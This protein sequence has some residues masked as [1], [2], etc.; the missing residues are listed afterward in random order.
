MP[1]K[2]SSAFSATRLAADTFLVKETDDIYSENPHIYV[3]LVPL[4]NTILL[5]DTGCGGKSNEDVEITSLRE[6]L[7]TYEVEVNDGKALNSGGFM[8]YV[9]VTTHCHYDHILAIEQFQGSLILASSHSPSFLSKANIAEHSLCNSLGIKTPSYDPTLVP[10]NFSIHSPDHDKTLLDVQI[11][12]TPGHTPDEIA[13]YDTTNNLLYVGDTLYED[14]PII[15]PKEGSIVVWLASMDFLI[16]FVQSIPNGQVLLNA[17][18]C[19]VN[20]PAL[21]MLQSAKGFIVDVVEGKE[22]VVKRTMKRGEGT[23]E[24]RQMGGR[25]S[26][27]CPEKLVLD[28]RKSL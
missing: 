5:I 28:A 26:L 11:L 22:K 18:H 20:K 1:L 15:F 4:V 24:Y 27:I 21:D 9:V 3:K 12:H 23:V 16:S 10:H 2:K 8:K 14:A 13:L 19:T 25:F 7:E 17:G 6:F